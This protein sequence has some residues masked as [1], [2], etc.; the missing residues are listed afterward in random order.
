MITHRVEPAVF[1]GDRVEITGDAYRHLFRARRAVVGERMRVVDGEGAARWAAIA[2]IARDRATLSLLDS[3]P[4]NDPARRVELFVAP[5][6]PERAA[7]LVEKASEL[8]VSAVRFVATAR[9]GREVGP[10]A[11]ERLRR[12]AVAGLEQSHGAR[13]PAIEGVV[14]WDAFL[15]MA[16]A[17]PWRAVL[18]AGGGARRA[19]D[20]TAAALLIGPEG[21]FEDAELATLERAG[22]VRWSL[23]GRALRVET[24]AVLAAGRLLAAAGAG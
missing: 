17:L 16:A 9:A 1:A 2:T 4:A 23:G 7:W 11:L 8:G 22:F 12:I 24:A 5:P 20:A 19:D 18:D 15:A 6:K 3:A 13:L 10:A 14:S 21:G